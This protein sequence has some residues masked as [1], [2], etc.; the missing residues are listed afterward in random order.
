MPYAHECFSLLGD[1][2][3][4]DAK[5]LDPHELT[6]VD[7]LICRSTLTVDS[8]L[9][10]YAKQ[11]KMVATA[12]AGFNHLD[13]HYL[14]NAGISWCSAAGCNA[15]AVAEYVISALFAELSACEAPIKELQKRTIGIVGAGNVGSALSQKLDALGI[16]YKLCDPP[17]AESGDSRVL[18]EMPE[19]LTCDVICL[20]VPLITQGEHPTLNL[21]GEEQLKQLSEKQI[22]IN[23]CRGGVLDENAFLRGLNQQR[24]PKLILDAWLNEPR[25]D[26]TILSLTAL[27]TPHIAGHTLEG[28]ARGTFMTYAS[29]CQLLDKNVRKDL[30]DLLPEIP[31][32]RVSESEIQDLWLIPEMIFSLYDI[33]LDDRHFRRL[34]AQSENAVDTFRLF[35][36]NYAVR[37]EFSAQRLAV[38]SNM[39]NN[40]VIERLSKL[41]FQILVDK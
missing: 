14:Q 27:A 2:Q 25:I 34:M 23:A 32:K 19:I 1:A 39:K 18:V 10:R 24:M 20:H 16:E 29:L 38:P 30:D 9:L 15:V 22:I 7:A 28:K 4:F 41:G 36:A 31:I 21:I 17:L 11:L 13:T 37:R 6:D 33:K 8:Q 3:S 12:T 5:T 26:Q 40:A 35:R